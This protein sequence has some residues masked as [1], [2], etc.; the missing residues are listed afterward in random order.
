MNRIETILVRRDGMSEADAKAL[1]KETRTEIQ[2][3]ID[4]GYDCMVEDIMYD[5]LG[6][7][8]DYIFDIL[9]F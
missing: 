9:G 8:M 1:V 5:N 3:A 4:A 2:E 6:L 7:E